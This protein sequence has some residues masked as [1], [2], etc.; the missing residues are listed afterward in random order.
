M[1]GIADELTRDG[2]VLRY[3]IKGTDKISLFCVSE[4]RI[5]FRPPRY[6]ATRAK[7]QYGDPIQV[8]TQPA[9]VQTHISLTLDRLPYPEQYCF[10][11]S[12]RNL[13]HKHQQQRCLTPMR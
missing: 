6:L 10:P 8:V 5:G 4:H 12:R 3:R 1:L 13:N 7:A 9:A 2:L 11:T